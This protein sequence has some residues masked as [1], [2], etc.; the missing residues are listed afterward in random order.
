MGIYDYQDQIKITTTPDG[1]KVV[2]MN[3]AILTRLFICL[4]DAANNQ[5]AKG[6]DA[7]ARDTLAL[8]DALDDDK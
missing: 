3:E 8:R 5:A 2:T 1:K 4:T 7:T 6:Y